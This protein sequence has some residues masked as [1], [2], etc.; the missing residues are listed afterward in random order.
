MLNLALSFAIVTTL[1]MTFSSLLV[2]IAYPLMSI[3]EGYSFEHIASIAV[4]SVIGC[5]LFK[6]GRVVP[7]NNI[8]EEE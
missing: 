5:Y 8:E 2:V 6:S 1:A 3:T 4:L 7:I